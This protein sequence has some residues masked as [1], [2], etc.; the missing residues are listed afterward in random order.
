MHATFNL[1]IISTVCP[2]GMTE[3]TCPV[4]QYLQEQTVLRPTV[5][6]TLLEWDKA[7]EQ[8]LSCVINTMLAKCAK[9]R[10]RK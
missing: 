5:N 8:Q 9:C 7:H 3:A 2:E 6:E 10:G 1:Q 4:R